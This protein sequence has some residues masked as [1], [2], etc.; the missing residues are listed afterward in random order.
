MIII[1]ILNGI[2]K[3]IRERNIAKLVLVKEML[4]Y[5]HTSE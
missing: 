4:Y 5:I 2:I 3:K 1:R